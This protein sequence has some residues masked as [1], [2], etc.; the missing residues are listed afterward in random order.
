MDT[1]MDKT[2]FSQGTPMLILEDIH[3]LT[4]KDWAELS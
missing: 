4:A 3:C 2:V 1:Q